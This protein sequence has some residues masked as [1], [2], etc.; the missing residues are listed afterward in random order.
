MA[1]P[2]VRWLPRFRAEH[3][4]TDETGFGLVSDV[5]QGDVGRKQTGDAR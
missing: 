5:C 3:D 2:C 1:M 4:V